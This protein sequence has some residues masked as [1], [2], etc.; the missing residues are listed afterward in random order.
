M[1]PFPLS[2][3]QSSFNLKKKLT[4]YSMNADELEFG[5]IVDNCQKFSN[6]FRVTVLVH[7]KIFTNTPDT[8]KVIEIN[9]I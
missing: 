3:M 7:L 1:G 6:I 5:P 9:Q 8:L 4:V 2:D